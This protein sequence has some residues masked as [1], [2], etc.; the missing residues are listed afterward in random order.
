M[1][2]DVTCEE[3]RA[4]APELSLGVADGHER[5]RALR[6]LAS[7]PACSATVAGYAA[8]ADRLL[9]LAPSI[10]PPAGFRAR[11]RAR[12]VESPARRRASVPGRAPARWMAV[13]AAIVVAVAIGAG[14][15]A[16]ITAQDRA[17]GRSYRGILS[18]GEGAF[19]TVAP[20][21]GPA[22]R[23]GTVWGYQGSPSWLFA[24]FAP[25]MPPGSYRAWLRTADGREIDLGAVPIDPSHPSWSASIPVGLTDVS[26]IRFT[27]ADG[28]SFDAALDP[29]SP[30]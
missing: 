7:C 2:G 24:S 29:R 25:G 16:R 27:A 20:L 30:W 23:A 8:T 13:A 26:G 10:P 18:Q 3:V 9:L 19:F 4:V 28:S 17:L 5:E 12:M 6:H 11:T 1:R 21:Q 22:G 15:T 14:T